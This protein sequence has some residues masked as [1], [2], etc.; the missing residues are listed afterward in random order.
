MAVKNALSYSIVLTAA[1]T[2]TAM[3]A[4]TDESHGASGSFPPFDSS[5]FTSQLFWLAVFFGLFY[6]L[7]SKVVLPRISGILEVRRDRIAQD[8]DEARKLSDE[9]DAAV[10]A[11]EQELAEA[12]ASA[13]TIA[14]SA[15]DEAKAKADEERAVVEADL[16]S[17]L[18]EAEKRIAGIKKAAL[19]DVGSIAGETTETLIKELIGGKLTKAEIAKAVSGK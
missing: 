13:H 12:K 1:G 15:R 18:A 16:A 6:Y 5:T 14:Q 8:L 9:S 19:A 3:A 2:A 11:Y 4:G 7:M 10:A 17:K